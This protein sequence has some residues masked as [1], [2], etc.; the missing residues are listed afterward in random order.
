MP[1]VT[2]NPFEMVGMDILGPFKTSVDGYNYVL[3]SV[4][5]YTSCVEAEP[6]RTIT[7][8][9]TCRAFFRIIFARHGC[10]SKVLTD[11]RSV[12][13]NNSQLR[14]LTGFVVSLR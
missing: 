2:S 1:I 3:T 4:D 6:L 9:E 8:G 13:T 12:K 5:M 11:Q 10:P 7:A 14:F